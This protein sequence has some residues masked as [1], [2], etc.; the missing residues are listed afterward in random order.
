MK[1]LFLLMIL[2]VSIC[3]TARLN[4]Q[5]MEYKN[6]FPRGDMKT[7]ALNALACLNEVLP[8]K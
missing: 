1:R 4:A 8:E 5:D 6:M 7:R 3:S 2:A